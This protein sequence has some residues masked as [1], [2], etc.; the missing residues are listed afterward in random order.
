MGEYPQTLLEEMWNVIVFLKSN[1][2]IT[3]KTENI[4][5]LLTNSSTPGNK[6]QNY[7]FIAALFVVA[8][9]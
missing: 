9:N 6:K 8:K 1:L 5:I 2:E 4:F 7:L 3:I